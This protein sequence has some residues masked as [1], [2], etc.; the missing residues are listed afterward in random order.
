MKKLII[1]LML[2][3][4]TTSIPAEAGIFTFIS[5]VGNNVQRNKRHRE[6]K[7][8]KKQNLQRQ[9]AI[10]TYHYKGGQRHGSKRF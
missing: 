3:M 6:F 4:L 10:Q 2:F 7:R 8:R 9:S 5:H 1:I